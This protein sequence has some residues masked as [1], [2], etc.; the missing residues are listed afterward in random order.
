MLLHIIRHA[1]PDYS[2]DSITPRGVDEAKA[3]ADRMSRRPIDG[4]YTSPLGRAIATAEP[5]GHALGM[6]PVVLDWAHEFSSP[7]VDDGVG[8]TGLAFW[9]VAGQYVRGGDLDLERPDSFPLYLEGEAGTLI[10]AEVERV[11]EGSDRWLA[12]IGVSRD[13]GV[14]RLA[15]KVPGEVAVVCHG[16]LGVTWVAHLLGLPVGL[17][18]CGL[19]VAPTSVTTVAFET[20]SPGIAVPRVIALGD[21]SHI[22]AAGLAEN[23]SGFPGDFG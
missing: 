8:R 11:R 20:R 1:D 14:Y 16:G 12:S 23:R 6:Q 19:F 7:L 13:G 4:L 15:D 10:A 9:N 18:W 22:Y 3:L 17:A 21:T 2:V 5:V